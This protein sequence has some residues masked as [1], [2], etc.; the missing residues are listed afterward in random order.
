MGEL[1]T[2]T[3][4]MTARHAT[5]DLK[6]T[7]AI[8]TLQAQTEIL[9]SQQPRYFGDYS[10]R[11]P[12]QG[13]Y[14]FSEGDDHLFVG[15]TSRLYQRLLNHCRGSAHSNR[16]SLKL[17]VMLAD[18][19]FAAP[20]SRKTSWGDIVKDQAFGEAFDKAKT[21]INKMQIRF[22][23]ENDSLSRYLLEAYCALA[24]EARYSEVDVL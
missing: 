11:G 16:S 21:R 9:V 20:A 13:V 14:L 22:I 4:L 10:D 19:K 17:S 6:F 3:R 18:A 15:R 8:S 1:L 7:R 12:Q 23:E 2:D 24:V 5:V